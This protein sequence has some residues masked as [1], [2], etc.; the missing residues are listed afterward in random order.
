MTP[1]SILNLSM[2]QTLNLTGQA[3]SPPSFPARLC[4]EGSPRF[5][6]AALSLKYRSE[7]PYSSDALV[8]MGPSPLSVISD[9]CKPARAILFRTGFFLLQRLRQL[10]LNGFVNGMRSIFDYET[11]VPGNNILMIR[12]YVARL[13]L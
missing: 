2:L 4:T 1:P 7:T 3:T 6:P 10:I 5:P 11:H 9:E 13:H 8:P 12:N